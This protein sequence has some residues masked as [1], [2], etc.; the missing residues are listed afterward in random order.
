[1]HVY[2]QKSV[3]TTFPRRSAS[4]R[5]AELSQAVA[6]GSQAGDPRL[7]VR[8]FQP[9]VACRRGSLADPAY[10]EDGIGERRRGFLG[11][12]VSDATLDRSVRIGAG[13]LRGIC[14]WVR[15]WCAVGVTL[16]RDGGH[17]DDRTFRELFLR[18]AVSSF[19]V[20]ESQSLA[21]VV[22]RDRDV[23][24]VLEGRD[25]AIEGGIVEGPFR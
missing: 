21:I 24:R 6:P 4:V 5:G 25:A 11:K 2:V 19:A 3:R 13:E 14:A 18:L 9:Y 1:M 22:N 15:M 7:V 10:F 8:P 17:G 12:V 23:I 20:G 16:E